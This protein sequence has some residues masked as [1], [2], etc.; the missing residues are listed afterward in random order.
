VNNIASRRRLIE[1]RTFAKFGDLCTFQNFEVGA[2]FSPNC[3]PSTWGFGALRRLRDVA[4]RGL[5]RS[6]QPFLIGP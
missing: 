2:T 3:K 4:C 5:E 1:E 6:G